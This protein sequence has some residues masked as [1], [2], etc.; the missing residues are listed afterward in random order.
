M[1]SMPLKCPLI[2]L[3]ATLFTS[4]ALVS[5]YKI[6]SGAEIDNKNKYFIDYTA[7]S[8]KKILLEIK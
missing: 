2:D 5:A 1:L 4:L 7:Y 6:M 3:C 8:I